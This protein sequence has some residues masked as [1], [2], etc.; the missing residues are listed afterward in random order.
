KQLLKT[1][2]HTQVTRDLDQFSAAIL[3]EQF[4]RRLKAVEAHVIQRSLAANAPQSFAENPALQ[5]DGFGSQSF[6]IDNNYVRFAA[7]V[8]GQ[9]P[10]SQFSQE[11]IFIGQDF[12]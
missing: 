2:G 3:P 4:P 9:P 1:A 10:V 5:C 6:S 12:C 7:C 11:G 8:P